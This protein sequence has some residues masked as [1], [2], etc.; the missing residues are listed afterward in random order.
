MNDITRRPAGFRFLSF[1]AGCFLLPGLLGS[2]S[3]AAEPELRPEDLPHFPPVEPADVAG[4]FVVRPGF[5]IELAAAEPE[6]MD[7][8][9]LSFD[10]QGRIYV[11]EMRD[12]SER[13]PERL[14]RVRR[15]EDRDG[16]GRYE[17]GTVFLEG[18][19]WPTAITCWDGGVFV[20]STPDL[21]Y[22]RDTDGDGK[23]D[24]REVVFTGFAS[25]F[26]PFA[27]NKLNVQAMM[28]SLQWGPDCRIHGCGSMSGGKLQRVRS[29]FTEAW[30][31]PNLPPDT[32]EQDA[33]LD[34]R[35]R[36]FSFDPRTLDLRL[37][38]GGGQYGMSFDDTGTKYLCSNSDHLQIARYDARYAAR[39]GWFSPPSARASIAA[40]G[41]AAEVF[42]ISPEEPWRVIRTRWRVTGLVQGLVEGGGRSSGYF[43]SATG[44]T[45]YRGDAYGPDYAGDVFIAD[46]GSNLVHR[47]KIRALGCDRVGERPPDERQREFL[48]SRDT[49][50]RPVQFANAPDGCLWILD[51]Y[52]EVIEHP[53]SLPPNLK[54][55]IDLDAGNDRGRLLRVV[56]EGPSPRRRVDLAGISLAELVATLDHPNGWHRDTAARLLFERSAPASVP[57]LRDFLLRPS[58]HSALGRLHALELLACLGHGFHLQDADLV[59]ALQDPAAPV[60]RAAIRCV[61]R[62]FPANPSL[63]SSLPEPIAT[64][65][66]PCLQDT[67]EVRLQL[68][69]T[70]GSIDHPRRTELL[71]SLLKTAKSDAGESLIAAAVLSSTGN[72]LARLFG[73]VAQGSDPD[74]ASRTEILPMLA[75]MVGRRNRPAEIAPV[76]EF[77]ASL[78]TSP[79]ALRTAVRLADGLRTAGASWESADPGGRLQA[80]VE[81]SLKAANSGQGLPG[82]DAIRLLAHRPGE[83]T[84]NALLAS[85]QA[86]RPAPVQRAAI[87][88][89]LRREDT[90]PLD[91]VLER[92]QQ[93]H[94]DAQSGFLDIALRRPTG[95]RKILEAIG[96]RRVEVRSLGAA[97]VGALRGHADAAIRQRALEL[98]GPPA[99]SRHEAVAAMLPALSLR[100]DPQRGLIVHQTQCATCHRLGGQGQA[101]G[102]D[103][104]SIRSQ[105]KEKLLVAILDP[106]REVQPAFLS[107]TVETTDGESLSGL[108]TTDNTAG[109]TLVQAGGIQHQIPRSQVA[110]TRPDGRSLMPEGF[111]ATLT[112][113]Q[114]ADL[115]AT[116]T[117]SP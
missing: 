36:D 41:P 59:A 100:G 98:L 8:V 33:P 92:W 106:N 20:G 117:G 15:L 87:E 53:W 38:T 31:R 90:A 7:P 93:L 83:A 13:R 72:D 104:E 63:K 113:Q 64:R 108:A 89:L 50:F 73:T 27:T 23:A 103:L 101:L 18:L 67:A 111:E 34:L 35:G 43:T 44:I 66:D 84:R 22:A 61:E 51:M 58:A 60:R 10:A 71:A 74:A 24:V 9:A 62:R 78:G 5:R 88:V 80:L 115:L 39:E 110:S 82:V 86:G 77:L 109:V 19:P 85:L 91:A 70:L 112:P 29:P 97:Q 14:G 42:R 99:A 69:F 75:E 79:I 47:K 1:L 4:S 68:A 76:V 2:A 3:L 55:L 57:L 52:R 6:V 116:L 96:D 45:V 94:P 37:E 25:D 54:R 30:R 114:M 65:L 21:L 16:D 49:W 105:P 32:V 95:A 102:P 11:V 40:D 12:Y 56:P 17:T 81:A 46:C 48:A 28:N 26:A 107:V